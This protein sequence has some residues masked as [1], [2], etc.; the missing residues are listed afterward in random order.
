MVFRTAVRAWNERNS[1]VI[2]IKT[3]ARRGRVCPVRTGG[4]GGFRIFLR[5]AVLCLATAMLSCTATE[6]GSASLAPTT[7]VPLTL[8]SPFRFDFPEDRAVQVRASTL[9]NM[10]GNTLGD[11]D[12][13][14]AFAG[15]ER[16]VRSRE[17]SGFYRLTGIPVD[18]QG[19]AFS[20]ETSN[21]VNDRSGSAPDDGKLPVEGFT[22]PGLEVTLRVSNSSVI[23]TA[24]A[25][26]IGRFSFP[27]V[28]F[29]EGTNT[30]TLEA[31]NS[32]GFTTAAEV[33]FVFDTRSPVITYF[34][35]VHDKILNTPIVNVFGTSDEPFNTIAYID[36][37]TGAN[38]R[39][40]N[41]GQLFSM[42]N[43]SFTEGVHSLDI[44]F[45]DRAGNVTRSILNFE[46]LTKKPVFGLVSPAATR[47]FFDGAFDAPVGNPL[48]EIKG[49]TT[50]GSVVRATYVDTGLPDQSFFVDTDGSFSIPPFNDRFGRPVPY[51]SGTNSVSIRIQDPA[52]N[53]T[54]PMVRLKLPDSF[55]A[56]VSLAVLTPGE[57]H[58][59]KVSEFVLPELSLGRL[60]PP[61]PVRLI[62]GESQPFTPVNVPRNLNLPAP[63]LPGFEA[64]L[65]EVSPDGRP[66]S[67]PAGASRFLAPYP[68]FADTI[69]LPGT[70]EGVYPELRAT[71]TLRENLIT[72]LGDPSCNTGRNTGDGLAAAL[73]AASLSGGAP[74]RS[75]RLEVDLPGPDNGLL[76]TAM[77]PGAVGNTLS[78]EILDPPG[79]NI[80]LTVSVFGTLVSVTLGSNA[81]GS[82]VSTVRDV[83]QAISFHAQA[84]VLVRASLLPVHPAPADPY[85]VG[86]DVLAERR[87]VMA[88]EASPST[89][90]SAGQTAVRL[91]APLGFI[92]E[93]VICAAAAAGR[94]P[95]SVTDAAS[96]LVIDTSG[97]ITVYGVDLSNPRDGYPVRRGDQVTVASFLFDAP[98]TGQIRDIDYV[99]NSFLMDGVRPPKGT[100]VIDFPAFELRID[101]N[102]G[103]VVSD[104]VT[105]AAGEISQLAP[106]L[107]VRL[108]VDPGGGP[109]AGNKL[110][111]VARQPGLPASPITFAITNPGP[112][113]P[114]IQVTVTGSDISVAPVTNGASVITSTARDIVR[115]VNRSAAASALVVATLTAPD[116][117]AGVGS[118]NSGLGAVLAIG[119]QPLVDGA[120]AFICPGSAGCHS[121]ATQGALAVARLSQPGA[122]PVN[123][124]VT[125]GHGSSGTGTERFASARVGDVIEIGGLSVN[126]TVAPTA[127]AFSVTGPVSAIDDFYVDARV[128][129]STGANSGQTRVVVDYDGAAQIL[130]VH[131]PLPAAPANGDTLVLRS[132]NA[133]VDFSSVAEGV[134]GLP[135]SVFLMA[136]A[137]PSSPLGVNQLVNQLTV[138]LATDATGEVVTTAA[139]LVAAVRAHTQASRLFRSA[140]PAGSAGSGV[141]VPTAQ[142]VPLFLDPR[143]TES[144]LRRNFRVLSPSRTGIEIVSPPDGYVTAGAVVDVT[145][146]LL[147]NTETL[148][149][150]VNGRAVQVDKTGRFV[151]RELPVDIGENVI[152]AVALDQNGRAVLANV[153][154]TRLPSTQSLVDI[155]LDDGVIRDGVLGTG[156]FVSGTIGDDVDHA[157]RIIAIGTVGAAGNFRPGIVPGTMDVTFLEPTYASLVHTTAT[158]PANPS[159]LYVFDG[160]GAGTAVVLTGFNGAST[161]TVASVPPPGARVA[162]V[163]RNLL[164]P[165]PGD[166]SYVVHGTVPALL[167]RNWNQF[168]VY[169]FLGAVDPL[170]IIDI[171]YLAFRNNLAGAFDVDG[172]GIPLVTTR[173]FVRLRNPV[174]FDGSDG[175][176]V[177]NWAGASTGTL[178]SASLRFAVDVEPAGFGGFE[179]VR[180]SANDLIVTGEYQ[181]APGAND[182]KMFVV[183]AEASIGSPGVLQIRTSDGSAIQPQ[184]NVSFAVLANSFPGPARKLVT[185][186][187]STSM[188]GFVSDPAAFVVADVF[189]GDVNTTGITVGGK[190]AFQ[191][192]D[193][194][195]V[196]NAIELTEGLNTLYVRAESRLHLQNL[197]ENQRSLIHY[198]PRPPA[199]YGLCVPTS[200]A[201]LNSQNPCNLPGGG[202]PV[203]LDVNGIGHLS[204][205]QQGFELRG[206]ADD[207]PLGVGIRDM[208]VTIDGV[209]VDIFMG[210]TGLGLPG[211]GAFSMSFN[212]PPGESRLVIRAVDL[213]GNPAQVTLFV[214]TPQPLPPYFTIDC[215]VDN[216]PLDASGA[217]V[218]AVVPY[219]PRDIRCGDDEFSN[220]PNS[221]VNLR[222]NA[223]AAAG[224]RGPRFGDAGEYNNAGQTSNFGAIPSGA[225][226]T[227]ADLALERRLVGA[228][229]VTFEGRAITRKAL[230]PAISING[231]ISQV[232]I[233][234]VQVGGG[235]AF[236]VSPSGGN[237]SNIIHLDP[238][239]VPETDLRVGDA[240]TLSSLSPS[241]AANVGLFRVVSCDTFPVPPPVPPD[242]ADPAI[243]TGTNVALDRVLPADAAGMTAILGYRWQ[244]EPLPVPQEGLNTYHFTVV[245]DDGVNTQRAYSVLRDTRP[246]AIVVNGVL[247]GFETFHASPAVLF[248]DQSMFFG[249]L[250]GGLPTVP[251]TTV[252]FQRLDESGEGG[253]V[254]P[255][256]PAREQFVVYYGNDTAPFDTVVAGADRS[257]NLDDADDAPGAAYLCNASL[258]GLDQFR[259]RSTTNIGL[260]QA[261][262]LDGSGAIQPAIPVRCDFACNDNAGDGSGQCDAGEP[263][264]YRLS[265]SAHDRVGLHSQLAV[266]FTI[267]QTPEGRITQGALGLINQ[268]PVLSLL[269][270]DPTE[271][272]TMLLDQL[273]VSGVLYN[274]NLH[275]AEL[276]GRPNDTPQSNPLAFALNPARTKFAL[277]VSDLLRGPDPNRPSESIV[278]GIL[279]VV[280]ILLDYGAG[281]D[282]LTTL[283]TPDLQQTYSRAN[284]GAGGPVVEGDP[285][286]VSRFLSELLA[287]REVTG[288]YRITPGEISRVF[289]LLGELLDF[290][291]SFRIRMDTVNPLDPRRTDNRISGTDLVISAAD[292][293]TLTT[294]VPDGFQPSPIVGSE[295]NVQPGDRVTVLS[296]ACTG[297]SRAVLEVIDSQTLETSCAP[298]PPVPPG[299]IDPDTFI[300]PD[301]NAPFNVDCAAASACGGAGCAFAI[302]PPPARAFVPVLEL[303][304][305]LSYANKDGRDALGASS[306]SDGVLTG[307]END[308]LQAVLHLA[309]EQFL[310][311]AGD[312][313]VI[314]DEGI[315]C[316]NDPENPAH[317]EAFADSASF[318][319]LNDL[320][321]QLSDDENQDNGVEFVPQALE[322]ARF[323][324]GDYDREAINPMVPEGTTRAQALLFL[325]RDLLDNAPSTGGMLAE[326]VLTRS[327]NPWAAGDGPLV[328]GS[329]RQ[330]TR[331][332]LL[333]RSGWFLSQPMNFAAT[334]DY[335]PRDGTPEA[336]LFSAVPALIPVLWQIA[337]DPDDNARG[338]GFAPGTF[339]E[340]SPGE[341]LMGPLSLIL[342]DDRLEDLLLALADLLDPGTGVS[343]LTAFADNGGR[344]L[345]R[346]AACA[347][348]D[349]VYTY[350]FT[351]PE[352]ANPYVSTPPLIRVLTQVSAM[353]LDANRNERIDAGDQTAMDAAAGALNALF[354]HIGVRLE[355]NDPLLD[356]NLDPV[357]G[358]VHT[359]ACNE[360]Y[361]NGDAPIELILTRL[362]PMLGPVTIDPREKSI[363]DHVTT[364]DPV[365]G[366]INRS[367]VRIILDALF[368]DPDVDEPSLPDDIDDYPANPLQ[369]LSY[370]A[371]PFPDP[372]EGNRGANGGDGLAVSRRTLDQLPEALN[373]MARFGFDEN[374]RLM[375]IFAYCTDVDAGCPKNKGYPFPF[376]QERLL[377]NLRRLNDIA[378]QF[379]GPF[380]VGSG[381]TGILRFEQSLLREAL[382][383]IARMSKRE[384]ID[385]IVLLVSRIS[386]DIEPINGSTTA[387]TPEDIA[388][389]AAAARVFADPDNDGD[390][391]PDGLLGDLIPL[392][393]AL[394]ATGATDQLVDILRA[395]RGCGIV[396]PEESILHQLKD[397]RGGELLYA[398]E[399]LILSL[400]DPQSGA[401]SGLCPAEAAGLDGRGNRGGALDS[402]PLVLE[403]SDESAP[404]IQPRSPVNA[405]VAAAGDRLR[406]TGTGRAFA[407]NWASTFAST[408]AGAPL[409]G[410]FDGTGLSGD[411]T[412]SL[413][414]FTTG[415]LAGQTSVISGFSAPTINV[416]PVFGAAPAPGDGFL[417]TGPNAD[418]RDLGVGPGASLCVVI[419]HA[420][421]PGGYL[422]SCAGIVGRPLPRSGEVEFND[423]VGLTAFMA[424]R[425]DQTNLPTDECSFRI[426]QL[427]EPFN[428][429]L[430]GDRVGPSPALGFGA[431]LG[432]TLGAFSPIALE[433]RG[434]VESSGGPG[435]FAGDRNF[436]ALNDGAYTGGTMR[437][438]NEVQPITGYAAA[439]RTFTT[440][441][442][443]VPPGAGDTV[444]VNRP[445]LFPNTWRDGLLDLMLRSMADLGAGLNQVDLAAGACAGLNTPGFTV[446]DEQNCY[447]AMDRIEQLLYLSITQDES[448][449]P[450]FATK[451]LLGG[452]AFDFVGETPVQALLNDE[453]ARQAIGNLLQLQGLSTL[454][455]N[456]PVPGLVQDGRDSYPCNQ[457][458][459]CD[460]SQTDWTRPFEGNAVND[461]TDFALL[462]AEGLLRVLGTRNGQDGIPR[463]NSNAASPL[464]RFTDDPA[465]LFEMTALLIDGGFPQRLLPGIQIAAETFDSVPQFDSTLA[466]RVRDLE[467]LVV[468]NNNPRFNSDVLA[469]VSRRVSASVNGDE[470]GSIWPPAS[471]PDGT[472]TTATVPTGQSAVTYGASDAPDV[473]EGAVQVLART[474]K[475]ALDE[476]HAGVGKRRSRVVST[477]RIA[478]HLLG[479]G[480]TPRDNTLA[481]ALTLVRYI[482]ED[483]D[484]ATAG[485][486]RN[487]DIIAPVLAVNRE[488]YQPGN[489]RSPNDTGADLV[490]L[491]LEDP[492]DCDRADQADPA[493]ASLGTQRGVFQ[494]GRVGCVAGGYDAIFD[495]DDQPTVTSQSERMLDYA[496]HQQLF[497]RLRP[498][499]AG[500]ADTNLELGLPF[501]ARVVAD[502]SRPIVDRDGF[503]FIEYTKGVAIID[504]LFS[505][506]KYLIPDAAEDRL[507]PVL[508]DDINRNGQVSDTGLQG[509]GRSA[510]TPARYSV[511]DDFGLV[512]NLQ[513][514]EQNY[515][516]VAGKLVNLN[517]NIVYDCSPPP[518]AAGSD[519]LVHCTNVTGAPLAAGGGYPDRRFRIGFTAADGVVT[520]GNIQGL[521]AATLDGFADLIASGH[522]GRAVNNQLP[523]TYSV[524]RFSAESREIDQYTQRVLSAGGPVSGDLLLLLEGLGELLLNTNF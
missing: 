481:R 3:H 188:S 16:S 192:P 136:P 55:H 4:T 264:T 332:N 299:I 343:D 392:A 58:T 235:D 174:W 96:R 286:R 186:Y 397:I 337:D 276:L 322:L 41:R 434:T 216:R 155:D 468:D 133:A 36:P 226:I 407:G 403:D 225:V 293:C 144:G 354:R 334:Y 274:Q 428:G 51:S 44:L 35:T 427:R 67:A 450:A 294:S 42:P 311:A 77:Q 393:Q 68:E 131:P 219:G 229:T 231:D 53:V 419:R 410:Q 93:G 145:G 194:S 342:R 86:D 271:L 258:P 425:C 237:G 33:E 24:V 490:A 255:D 92:T 37:E 251:A 515:A 143:R 222:G 178:A 7:V 333:L 277:F 400:L 473:S 64:R 241:Q 439:T 513:E 283:N 76:V 338:I 385:Y 105:N 281:D 85:C 183:T 116:T 349:C 466:N 109:G 345:G 386:D 74:G 431:G 499:I 80:P 114:S 469:A 228:A 127:A 520:M 506:I 280:R 254:P 46:V 496:L 195:F 401:E 152:Q 313:S 348:N 214:Q 168:S 129:F 346:A 519:P 409:A 8:T 18:R 70:R 395:V 327:P 290:Q 75:A 265:A 376:A 149:V 366:N 1:D 288:G 19:V 384:A 82:I 21:R 140:L 69:C 315:T 365:P 211:T 6:I 390:P 317:R 511:F 240:V 424:A 106:A 210:P 378:F 301:G 361:F 158:R 449:Q 291:D 341:K 150:V 104:L 510:L 128:T 185:T 285:S 151:L 157:G 71:E 239:P 236:L 446:A 350:P 374:D 73:T 261:A 153:T 443:A 438:G 221:P 457:G 422:E 47:N 455:A 485:H 479:V 245:D 362:A 52:G 148:K 25:D 119:P 218:P 117:H 130:T 452:E 154:V 249:G 28:P 300:W 223:Y 189:S 483:H 22:E 448:G 166:N 387:L 405:G 141:M 110:T 497:E 179:D 406:L 454:S 165:T 312:L 382:K 201:P 257:A 441:P 39:F 289:P 146:R 500:P 112:S 45:T 367:Q 287:T 456:D 523:R 396:E 197:P 256:E 509:T 461:G 11:V 244:S 213:A 170:K 247:S 305:L 193:G 200:G 181:G 126:S 81:A 436:S 306:I 316:P 275:L 253:P 421:E 13:R 118:S 304:D 60:S 190:Q 232:R 57:G 371:D 199:I 108:D 363:H 102:L 516:I 314:C 320:L 329:R 412:G 97:R 95:L 147:R 426:R 252:A 418:L 298:Y 415:V 404:G 372:V 498:L 433:V 380:Q 268:N 494:A 5:T 259:V 162:L 477:E 358:V 14:I 453:N 101:R 94:C 59:F 451:L 335:T 383:T 521:N 465:V 270:S 269:L 62:S 207:G 99:S 23:R 205:N 234:G 435:S 369:L 113:N 220:N 262:Y 138:S 107:P 484:I 368:D 303:A 504:A 123:V 177:P 330:N 353:R 30:V 394:S 38:V 488:A 272:N 518:G 464:F 491:W 364:S 132:A 9:V 206:F 432:M 160:I 486:D 242:L 295:S 124:N 429:C 284:F 398:Q 413:V 98:V 302:T 339:P 336:V 175:I 212:L 467:S 238:L 61:V 462:A 217:P 472:E 135:L 356:N 230:P 370:P 88:V 493:G 180:V 34:S 297:T 267:V 103:F 321:Y 307:G 12:V 444:V 512:G 182:G 40:L 347:G 250:V 360:S 111:L 209:P 121:R 27:D 489:N 176:I 198:D 31:S 208:D 475:L 87:R 43:F 54:Q 325:A 352:Q 463:A 84:S 471:Y 167:D 169:H 248:T 442:F 50:P 503:E 470:T 355:L 340:R 344:D 100:A 487:L 480:P 163:E 460:F 323:M 308:L 137:V 227:A 420:D 310:V 49:F 233:L 505:D 196:L 399:D 156:L 20:L 172:V 79:A 224:A 90:C 522:L 66:V 246:P 495:D 203:A 414:T 191:F 375:S 142:P 115:A 292:H 423:L 72:I 243:C 357:H 29:N 478:A 184:S 32:E 437:F 430:A 507:D 17:D 78:L 351:V 125:G 417:I 122:E 282:L 260:I 159:F 377:S 359:N 445:V 309:E 389:G 278:A 15:G 459:D 474:V 164:L 10:S 296:G 202:I 318:Q 83:V 501:L 408:V 273:A 381:V 379:D 56:D 26:E 65:Y 517:D 328:S 492:T 331:L 204:L 476:W 373:V 173:P 458:P 91:A 319:A 2:R 411:L 482:T 416:S 279:D 402:N 89:I 63:P 134:S 524:R 215:F 391:L 388:K 161:I 266:D 324:L 171:S 263:V 48:E 502:S 508:S 440:A 447:S 187:P 120:N 139:E 326:P 514:S